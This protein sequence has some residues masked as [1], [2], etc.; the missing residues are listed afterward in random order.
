[1][2]SL[3]NNAPAIQGII[4]PAVENMEHS[5]TVPLCIATELIMVFKASTSPEIDASITDNESSESKL[6]AKI[7]SASAN[8][9]ETPLEKVR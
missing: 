8:A 1:M 9:A 3:K 2:D 4:S 7:R 6:P 5:A